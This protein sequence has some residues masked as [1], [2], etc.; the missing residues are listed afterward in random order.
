MLTE[1]DTLKA[2]GSIDWMAVRNISMVRANAERDIDILIA[3]YGGPIL[4]PAGV[5]FHNIREW[6]AELA[7]RVDTTNLKL[8]PYL[9]LYR[10]ELRKIWSIARSLQVVWAAEQARARMIAES[11]PAPRIAVMDMLIASAEHE[12]NVVRAVS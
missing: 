5:G 12:R 4:K 1:R 9:N 6:R 11:E 2:D 8:T 7:A 3:A 10:A